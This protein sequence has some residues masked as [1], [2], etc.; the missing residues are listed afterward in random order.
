MISAVAATLVLSIFPA[1]APPPRFLALGDSYTIGESVAEADRW[2]NQLVRA[3]RA[4]KTIVAD[5]E[6]IA[7]TGWTTDE[8]WAAIDAAKPHGPY[9]LV[10]L[11]IGVNNQY[12]GRDA[13]QYRKEFVALLHRAIGFA[14]GDAK[15][16]IVVS[17]PDW[18]ATPF[19][20]GRDR[21]KIGA[22]IDHFNAIAREEAVRT[23]AHFADVTPVSRHAS[24]DPTLV[25]PDGLH[26]SAKM[27]AQWVAVIEPEA[28]LALAR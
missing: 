21:A 20:E 2:P 25:A 6:I 17:I 23:G 4:G 28:R 16:V 13:E 12:R 26:P 11:L 22:E 5:P 3:L 1:N 9:S 7:K 18:G 8:L 14:G 27:Y 10:T 19:A 15:R 24:T